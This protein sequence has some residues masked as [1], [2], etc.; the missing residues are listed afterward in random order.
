MLLKLKPYFHIFSK[1]YPVEHMGYSVNHITSYT[2][3]HKSIVV[4]LIQSLLSVYN[5]PLL[6]MIVMQPMAFTYFDVLT[7]PLY[8]ILL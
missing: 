3:T 6:S 7:L 2:Y 1:L 8:V 5:T 4:R